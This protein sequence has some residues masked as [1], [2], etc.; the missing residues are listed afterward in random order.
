MGTR[1]EKCRSGV[2]EENALGFRIKIETKAF[3]VRCTNDVWL[4][5]RDADQMY[6]S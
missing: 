1:K 5:V 3:G 4:N 6:F 2:R